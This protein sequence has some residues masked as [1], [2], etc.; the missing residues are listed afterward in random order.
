MKICCS[1][2]FIKELS[3]QQLAERGQVGPAE[4]QSSSMKEG[5]IARRQGEKQD[6]HAMLRKGLELLG[7]IQKR[8]LGQFKF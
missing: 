8:K 4:G 7:R 1:P 5:G 3:D 2:W 6:E